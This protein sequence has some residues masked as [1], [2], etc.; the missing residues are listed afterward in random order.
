M[1]GPYFVDTNVL[2]YARDQDV[3]SKQERARSW[4]QHLW[5]TQQGRVSTQVLNE[6]YYTVTRK[7]DPTGDREAVRQDIRDLSA[8]DPVRIDED[9]VARAWLIEDRNQVSYW[10]ALIVAASQ[11]AGCRF[12]LTEDLQHGQL[13]G[14]VEIVSPFRATPDEPEA[15]AE[16]EATDAGDAN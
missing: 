7:L 2:V 16:P 10:D 9:L 6:Y 12:L 13:I 4:L 1:T 15:T 11:L 5:A 3:P 8:W 14:G